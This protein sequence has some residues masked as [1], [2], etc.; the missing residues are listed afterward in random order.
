[1]RRLFWILLSA[2]VFLICAG[3]SYS[4]SASGPATSSPNSP[5]TPEPNLR[6]TSRLVVVDVVVRKGNQPVTGL[7]QADF[8]LY[9]DGVPQT[10]R[11][12]TPHF[13]DPTASD[14]PAIKAQAPSL[15]PDTW[16]NL[17]IARVSDSVTVLLL[18][19]LNTQPSDVQYVRRET[20]S[21]LKKLPSG[22][23]IAV[24]VLGHE[25]RM[26]QGFTADTSQ[27]LA[28]LEKAN[29]TSPT[30]LLPPDDQRFEEGET[31]G[32]A[33]SA[34]VSPQEIADLNNFMGDADAAQTAMRVRMTLGAMQQLAR[35]LAG[36]Q[37]RKNLV[38][39]SG[40][41][42]VQFFSI[43]D[44]VFNGQGGGQV[45]QQILPLDTFD[46]E[47]RETAD[48]LAAAR[49]AV[50]PVDVRG[51]LL[52][53]MFT[54]TQPTTLCAGCPMAGPQGGTFNSDQQLS[55]V[56]RAAEH[57]TEDVLAQQTGGRAV[58][59]SNGL[60]EAMADTI[61]DGSNF[62]TL[63][64]V[65]TN[66]N[67]NGAQRNIKVSLNRLKDELFYRRSYYADAGTFSQNGAAQDSRAVFLESMRRG[68]PASSQIVFDV[69]VAASDPK[70]PSGSV[71]G[72]NP[73]MKNRAARYVIDYAADLHSINLTE[74]PSG[75]RK[76]NLDALAI[77]YDRDGNRLN[78][79]GNHVPI[80][81]DQAASE[82]YGRYGLQIHQVLDLPVGEVYLRLGLYDPTSSHIGTLEI[83]LR[84]ESRK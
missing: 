52:Q 9:E 83:P 50:Y 34:R 39:L 71:A 69:H 81:F 55:A 26:L 14:A 10:I 61:S 37:G 44:T 60:Q 64:Y 30:S 72:E 48:L 23:P 36:S 77:A 32:M 21:Y 11:Y 59:D 78:W 82:Q 54:S 80:A 13:A 12:F 18:D 3:P 68:V 76:G 20:I 25:L 46:T 4:Q 62:Y 49:V 35:Y 28:A 22:R 74:T 42:P 67:Y 75:V 65:P 27:L 8:A 16:T 38:W 1:M 41:F 24:F 58:Y 2:P 70:A 40:A 57:A 17:P 51:V 53:P 84:I 56:Q 19:G 15:P 43:V 66:S 63:A 6:V 73:A 45:R 7:R 29:A 33:A 47:V 31:L 79:V 5:K